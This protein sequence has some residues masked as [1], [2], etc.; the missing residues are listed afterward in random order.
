[1]PTSQKTLSMLQR[2]AK[3]RKGSDKWH[4]HSGRNTG[5]SFVCSQLLTEGHIRTQKEATE[6]RDGY[7]KSWQS[8]CAK[9][10]LR[11]LE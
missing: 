8:F 2:K 1:M 6:D 11:C 3:S 7:F 4:R 5:K 10:I 9:F